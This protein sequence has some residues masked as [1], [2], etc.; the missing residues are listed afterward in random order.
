MNFKT[1]F[2]TMVVL[3]LLLSLNAIGAKDNASAIKADVMLNPN[4]WKSLQTIDDEGVVGERADLW[5][6]NRFWFIGESGYLI[7]GFENRPGKH[8]WQGEHLGKWLHAG[9]IACKITGDQK[10]KAKMD[11]STIVDEVVQQFTAKLGVNVSISVEI[12]A[13]SKEGFDEGVQRTIKENCNVLKFS[14]AEFEG[15]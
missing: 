13:S 5:R 8:P 6:N 15:E 4:Q 3:S 11:F 7:D 14:N 9:T 10:M 2:I 12:Q 1:C